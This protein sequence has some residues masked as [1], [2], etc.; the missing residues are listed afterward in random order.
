M[1]SSCGLEHVLP[2]EAFLNQYYASM[3]YL[4]WVSIFRLIKNNK[5]PSETKAVK[6]PCYG[7][8][9]TNNDLK[10]QILVLKLIKFYF[11]FAVVEIFNNSKDK[12]NPNKCN[13]PN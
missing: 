8:F 13:L 4:L 3:I 6:I 12:S 2:H 1:F 10:P 7:N 11:V 5:N 9:M